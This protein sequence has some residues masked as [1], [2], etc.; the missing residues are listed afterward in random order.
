MPKNASL[1]LC[2]SYR[3]VILQSP[4][5]MPEQNGW[6]VTSSLP[7]SK[8]EAHRGGRGLAEDLLAVARIEPVQDRSSRLA[9]GNS[10]EPPR[11]SE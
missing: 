1:K 4:G 10:L 6:A 7:R 9:T 8:V 3:V 2:S 5:P 11:C